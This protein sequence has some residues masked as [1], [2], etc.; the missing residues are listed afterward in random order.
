MLPAGEAPLYTWLHLGLE[1]SAVQQAMWTC[2]SCC[3][4][5]LPLKWQECGALWP[6]PGHFPGCLATKC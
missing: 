2:S 1:V 4:H 3:I 5:I 6:Q